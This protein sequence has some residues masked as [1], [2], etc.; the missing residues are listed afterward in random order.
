MN[1]LTKK[2]EKRLSNIFYNKKGGGGAFT[3]NFAIIKNIYNEKYPQDKIKSSLVKQFLQEQYV[4]QRHKNRRKKFSRNM[5]YS[6]APG[7][8]FGIDLADFTTFSDFNEGFK[9]ILLGC[10]IFSK[11][12][13]AEPL[14]AK[15]KISVLN[16]FKKML[17]KIKHRPLIVCSDLGGEFLAKVFQNYL[18][19]EKIHFVGLQ[20]QY[21][22]SVTERHIRTIKDKFGRLWSNLG[23]PVWVKYLQDIINS[24]NN[25]KH[26]RL[27]VAPNEVEDFNSDIIHK[28]L[29]PEKIARVPGRFK[30][31]DLVRISLILDA[32]AKAYEG[33]FSK[34]TFLISRG[35]FYSQKGKYPLYKLV[36]SYSKEPVPGSWYEF[37]MQ[38]INKNKFGHSKNQEYDIKVL[39]TAGKNSKIHYVG[40][41]KKYDQWVPTKSLIT[42]KIK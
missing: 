2:R 17:P 25:T 28:R 4:Y 6:P 23:E 30:K 37:E 36:E 13:Y 1:K 15:D 11:M 34:Q 42:R 33:L 18:K 26:S 32:F 35:P 19:K 3:A 24:Y 20:G 5:V 41:S 12:V 9:Y 21:H 31:G 29:Y 14:K 40:W 27:K 22:N 38:K 39:E 16:A 10:D 7:A 8:W